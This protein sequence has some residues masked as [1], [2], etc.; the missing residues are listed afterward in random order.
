MNP[1]RMNMSV[2]S[3][4][5]QIAS[6][7]RLEGGV[8]VAEDPSP[9]L[10]WALGYCERAGIVMTSSRVRITR[11]LATMDVPTTIEALERSAELRGACD[12]TTLY[13]TMGLFTDIELVRQVRWL[14]TNAYYVLN[15]P[16]D[17]FQYLIC[18]YCERVVRLGG[19]YPLSHAVDG[20]RLPHDFTL[21]YHEVGIYG[22]C[23]RCRSARV[24]E[25]RPTKL[26]ARTRITKGNDPEPVRSA[27]VRVRQDP[28]G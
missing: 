9:R 16:G 2:T 3:D 17:S 23:P 21:L 4:S 14:R 19:E 10:R 6:T 28:H 22:L 12:R 5:G 27:Q 20:V 24:A 18:P 15:M 25:P 11:Y 8:A 26:R 7:Q 13:R 1:G